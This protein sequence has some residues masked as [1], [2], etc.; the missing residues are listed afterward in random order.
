VIVWPN[1]SRNVSPLMV[2][3]VASPYHELTP[4]SPDQNTANWLTVPLSLITVRAEAPAGI[5]N[6]S[7]R[8]SASH[9]RRDMRALLP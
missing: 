3:A 7:A 2:Y 9:M 1:S 5:I 8:I 6:S 4:S